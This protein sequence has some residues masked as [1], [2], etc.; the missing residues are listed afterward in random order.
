[1]VET[2]PVTGGTMNNEPVELKARETPAMLEQRR[3]FKERM[4]REHM[5]L[6]W[7]HGRPRHD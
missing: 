7:Y 2:T 3:K 5:A 1:M 6:G 4:D